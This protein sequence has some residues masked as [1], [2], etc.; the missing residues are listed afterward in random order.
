MT[1]K[2]RVY[3]RVSIARELSFFRENA[4]K[5]T[6]DGVAIS[7]HIGA[8]HQMLVSE[9]IMSL[10]PSY[11]V[12]PMTYA[13]QFPQ[14]YMKRVEKDIDPV[15]DRNP[16]LSFKKLANTYGDP[17]SHCVK[18]NGKALRA[19]AFG[20]RGDWNREAISNFVRKVIEFEKNLKG[21]KSTTRQT[22]LDDI[23]HWAGIDRPTSE[24]PE[25]EFV[26]P[27]YFFA[28]DF[29][30]WYDLSLEM[31]KSS[32]AEETDLPVYPVIA[33]SPSLLGNEKGMLRIIEDYKSFS[34]C[35]LW[36]NGLDET[37]AGT[38][39]LLALVELIKGF[40]KNGVKVLGLYGGYFSA[41]LSKV[42]MYGFVSGLCY[43]DFRYAAAPASIGGG[44]LRYYV[45]EVSKKLP[46]SEA[47][48]FYTKN[49][50]LL[51]DCSYCKKLRSS[52]EVEDLSS[53]ATLFF[54]TLE[55]M[56]TGSDEITKGHFMRRRF[57][58]VRAIAAAPGSRI[59]ADLEE[60]I[61]Q[62]KADTNTSHL[63]NWQ[64]AL[65]DTL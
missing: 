3:Y 24:W 49:M 45:P 64:S 22:S 19:S 61:D 33:V 11:F 2:P 21:D 59:I 57:E 28:D 27:P 8:Y 32:I 15:E 25:P 47:A 44:K 18:P 35:L 46:L 39:R 5:D 31:A 63:L 40:K 34:G 30:E 14:R 37:V 9:Y 12:D 53:M 23:S 13:F 43:N 65:E 55:G 1:G 36:L 17:V 29:G 41:L 48:T 58:E 16:K 38:S 10:R 54:L 60:R 51:C 6:Y 62:F 50:K 26:V 4:L 20:R 52:I 56:K 7:A 42:G